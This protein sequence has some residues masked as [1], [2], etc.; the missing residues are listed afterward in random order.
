MS[1]TL[2]V[3]SFEVEKRKRELLTNHM[4]LESALVGRENVF[5]HK[6]CSFLSIHL[7]KRET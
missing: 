5:I 2:N 7:L 6:N 4:D 3:L 1:K